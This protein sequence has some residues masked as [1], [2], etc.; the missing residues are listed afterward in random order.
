MPSITEYLE[1]RV[2]VLEKG[3]EALQRDLQNLSYAVKEQ[4]TQLTTAIGN[5]VNAH[6]NSYNSLSDKISNIGKTDWLT[7][8]T[9]IG[10]LLLMLGAVSTP[11]W[12]NFNSVDKSL[13]RQ[14]TQ[15]NEFISFRLETTRDI[16]EIKAKIEKK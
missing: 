1:P 10:V 13:I 14:D 12:L 6:N 3:Q 9:M 7:F 15:I 11:V 8:W 16:A 2:S 4:G 5:L